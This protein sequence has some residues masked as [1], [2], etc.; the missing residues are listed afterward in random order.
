VTWLW[1]VGLSASLVACGAASGVNNTTPRDNVSKQGTVVA[2]DRR[3]GTLELAVD[4]TWP[5]LAVQTV[6]SRGVV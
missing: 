2:I 3:A 6:T 4:L 5:P 1:L